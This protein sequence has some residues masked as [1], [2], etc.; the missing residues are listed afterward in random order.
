MG[1]KQFMKTIFVVACILIGL[2]FAGVEPLS[3]YKDTVIGMVDEDYRVK[4][5]ARR[6]ADEAERLAAGVVWKWDFYKE[7]VA[8]FN[9]FRQEN[10]VPPL[11]FVPD[12][13]ELAS[14]RVLQ[15]RD[16]FSHEGS[17]LGLG[18]NIA[19]GY[20]GPASFLELWATSPGHRSNMLSLG[21]ST[22]GFATDGRYAVQI[23][24]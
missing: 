21:Y 20:G 17:P 2:A 9:E 19:D 6:A 18:E 23:F 11:T 8:L 5:E 16:N 13:N 12:L 4:T 10:G 15:I 7:Y 22:T 24:K 1:V 3:T 14:W